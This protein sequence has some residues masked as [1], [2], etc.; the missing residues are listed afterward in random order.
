MNVKASA[1]STVYNEV[2]NTID[3]FAD[4][5]IPPPYA[6]HHLLSLKKVEEAPKEAPADSVAA[7]PAVN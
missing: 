2:K 3:A 4:G 5:K 6:F 7:A 1:D